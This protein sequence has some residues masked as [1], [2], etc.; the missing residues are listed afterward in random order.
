MKNIFILF[1]IF[2]SCAIL[3][4]Q[5][6]KGQGSAGHLNTGASIL[7]FVFVDFEDSTFPPA[8]WSLEYTGAQT[9]WSRDT[10]C[11]GYG[12]GAGSAN[13]DFYDANTGTTQS[14]IS[15]VFQAAS[16]TDSLKFDHAYATYAT[17]ND[18]LEIDYSTNGGVS[19]L[20][21]VLLTGGSSGTLVTAPPTPNLFVPTP[22][23]WASKKFSLPVG[24]NRLKFKAISGFGNNLY[25]DNIK[26]GAP[27]LHDAGIQS[28]TTGDNFTAG[29]PFSPSCLVKNFGLSTESFNVQCQLFDMGNNLLFTTTAA[30]SGLI[31]G[32]TTP[33]NFSSCSLPSP[34]TYY[35]IKF[36]TQLGGDLN[37]LN[38]TLSKFINS[39]TIINKKSVCVEIA[40]GIWCFYC[41]G[42]QI[43]AD[44]LLNNGC[45]VAVVEYHGPNLSQDSLANNESMT[46]LSYYGAT[47]YP[48]AYFDGILS[49]VGGDHTISQYLK[50]R[51][52]YE[53][54]FAVKTAIDINL[55]GYSVNDTTYSVSVKVDR[56]APFTH[57]NTNLFLALTETHIPLGWQG[58][59]E[60]SN[61][62]RRMLPD[63][64]GLAINMT[65]VTTKTVPF[66]LTLNPAWVKSNCKLIAFLQDTSSKEIFNTIVIPLNSL[67]IPVELTSFSVAV[68]SGG[69]KLDWAT[70][71]ET[72]N[73]GFEI[74]K[75][76][77]NK[78]FVAVG[79]VSG[80]GTTTEPNSYS[81]SENIKG[82]TEIIYYRL[83]QIDFDGS[84]HLSSV[85]SVSFIPVVYSLSQNYPNPFN[86][87]T[88]ISY[89]VP[90]AGPVTIKVYNIAGAEVATLVNEVKQPG[91]Y[92]VDFNAP[93]LAS[94]IY[95]Y[96]MI[97]GNF[98]EI[99]KMC[100]IK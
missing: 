48:T 17:E 72:N 83:R 84:S 7:G 99:K 15:S 73:K 74:Q 89:T 54:Q 30:V 71:T 92:F 90:Q 34:N 97:S 61:C 24:T 95:F 28:I 56:V 80:K 96:K 40:T 8:G 11:S 18:Q 29:T 31:S 65:T 47:G 12:I 13:F 23:Q 45:K 39:L 42:S 57:T 64:K 36:T 88:K 94:G 22:S 35:W 81:F 49:L 32:A 9:F 79:F 91:K 41:P 100:L 4:A 1:L 20:Q 69:V 58:Q 63:G 21:L 16:S 10:V 76:F 52:L 98:N 26:I 86:P 33:V 60:V 85:Q 46:R 55:F 2:L 75:S 93:K 14:L 44:D 5:G 37:S 67:V 66:T 50:Y 87:A 3:T 27:L 6:F 53:Q 62:E 19:W 77:D 70:A 38:D 43:G 59:T 51:T 25:L 82:E 78:T 68:V